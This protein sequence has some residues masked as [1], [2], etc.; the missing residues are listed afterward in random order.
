M[1]NEKA[2][3]EKLLQINAIKLDPAHP[4]TWAS[5]WKSPIYCDNRR[6]L[7]F[8]YIREFIKSE[9][10][11]VIFEQFP[12]AAMLAGVA[13]AGIA[14]GAMAADQLKLPFIYVRPKPKEHG[15]GNQIEGFYEPGQQVVVIEDLVSTGKSS[16]QVV[17]LLQESGLEVVGMVSIFNYGFNTAEQAF[18]S[19]SLRYFS[20][21][22]YPT[23][24]N[25][26][27]E[28]AIV[29][30]EQEGILLNWSSDPANWKGFN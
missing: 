29:S 28:K 16:L 1:T 18:K 23:L 10:C 27:I 12:E 15:L 5:G 25:L 22:N 24:I 4:F 8:P 19:R 26:A 6:V 11:N 2:V 14:W 20:L 7:S 30:S 13:T 9:M 21:T 3:A 17:D